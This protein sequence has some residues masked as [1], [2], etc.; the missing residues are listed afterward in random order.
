MA[1]N[2]A[3][4]PGVGIT[5]AGDDI[6]GVMSPRIKVQW[7]ADGTAT[8]VSAAAPMPVDAAAAAPTLY[9]VT[10]T[11]ANTEYSQALPNPTR[12]ISI[13]CRSA[14]AIRYAWVTGKVAA[15]TDPYQTIPANTEYS[16]DDIKYT[17]PTLYLASASAG[18][19]VEIEAWS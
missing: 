19:I 9:A 16:M 12:G 8:D 11:S 18:V 4:T 14:A 1:D 13:K 2:Y 17:S 6:G 7:G 3:A 15:P 10:L 5:F